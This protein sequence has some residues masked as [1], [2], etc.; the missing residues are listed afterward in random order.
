MSQYEAFYGRLLRPLYCLGL[1]KRSNWLH[2]IICR[3]DIMT[4]TSFPHFWPFVRVMV[5]SSGQGRPVIRSFE[6]IFVCL[7]INRKL[8][9]DKIH[10]KD[11]VKH[12][13][14]L[15]LFLN[16]FSSLPCSFGLIFFMYVVDYFRMVCYPPNMCFPQ[17]TCVACGHKA[18]RIWAN[19]KPFMAG[20]TSSALLGI[21]D[22][23]Y[24]LY[25]IIFPLCREINK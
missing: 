12:R 20:V 17:D 5:N 15:D 10:P 23:P 14:E 24:P 18:V 9:V 7:K 25:V 4:W 19:M 22:R 3:H 6:S 1:H 21:S 11:H 16:T 2:G 8:S 13:I